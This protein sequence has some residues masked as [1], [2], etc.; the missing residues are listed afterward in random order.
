MKNASNRQA[1]GHVDLSIRPSRR[2]E[3]RAQ[4]QRSLYREG[5][6]SYVSVTARARDVDQSAFSLSRRAIQ[7]RRT[8]S[9]IRVLD[10][11]GERPM[12]PPCGLIHASL[13]LPRSS[14]RSAS[15]I[16]T[17]ESR[18]PLTTSI[19][20]EGLTSRPASNSE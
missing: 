6:T 2:L 18:A 15:F 1:R 13:A 11:S 5:T 4:Q 14:S 16:G 12:C 17:C 7:G 10:H 3:S 19:G 20:A 9:A 8:F